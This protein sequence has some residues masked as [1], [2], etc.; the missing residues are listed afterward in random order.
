MV[1]I[2][3]SL[4]WAIGQSIVIVAFLYNEFRRVR[5]QV[6]EKVDAKVDKLDFEK[7]A[8]RWE[9]EV[10]KMRQENRETVMKLEKQY[11]EKFTK[12]FDQLRTMIKDTEGHLSEQIGMVMRMIESGKK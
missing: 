10:E 3:E 5:A 6:D 7:S 9:K 8:D 12:M 1:E 2:S 4:K 11:D